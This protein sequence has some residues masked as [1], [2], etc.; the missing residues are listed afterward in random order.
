MPIESL[1]ADILARYK[2]VHAFCKARS[3]LSRASVYLVLS[4]KY[5]GRMNAQ[6]ARIRA[7]LAEPEEERPP[8]MPQ[9]PVSAADLVDTLQEIR[10][11]H[12]RRLDRREC[13]SCRD[14]TGRAGSELFLRIFGT[15]EV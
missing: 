1:K 6:I 5:P 9:P 12:C 4:G 13:M 11:T 15:S 3:E 14:Q 10:C 8:Q 7:A 2:S